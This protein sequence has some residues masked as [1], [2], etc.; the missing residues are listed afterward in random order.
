MPSSTPRGDEVAQLGQEVEAR[1]GLEG[2]R[3]AAVT[4]RRARL[5]RRQ[6]AGS[7]RGR[8]PRQHLQAGLGGIEVLGPASGPASASSVTGVRTVTGT[9][10]SSVSFTATFTG[11]LPVGDAAAGGQLDRELAQ[12]AGAM[13][14]IVSVPRAL[15]NGPSA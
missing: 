11:V 1:L 8:S 5:E 10:W 4:W 12:L 14:W 7:R 3:C 15:P 13:T 2:R 6:R 9:P